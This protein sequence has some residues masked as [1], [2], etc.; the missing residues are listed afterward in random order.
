M[1]TV[2]DIIAGRLHDVGCRH[3]FGMPGGEVL[4]VMQALDEAGIR[5]VLTKHENSAGYMAEGSHHATG[6][7]GV[8]LTT[9]GPGLANA[10]NSIANAYQD[11]VPLIVLSGCIGRA[12]AEHFTHQVIDQAALLKPVSKAQFQVTQGSVCEVMEKALSIALAD[13]P[14]PVHIDV[15][16]HIAG[17]PA[18]DSGYRLV[19][20]EPAIWQTGQGFDTACEMINRSHKPIIIA[21]MGALHHNVAKA[22]TQVSE[23]HRVPVITTYKAKGILDENSTHCLGGHGLSPKSDAH[24]LR[25]LKEA[26]CIIGVGYDPIEM[27]SGW[28]EPWEREKFV[29]IIHADIGHGMHG[30]K[31][32]FV[33][34]VGLSLGHL[35]ENA[36]PD[37]APEW[38]ARVDQTRLELAQEFSVPKNWGPHQAFDIARKLL[39][40]DVVIT[41]DSGA[42]RILLSQMWK[43]AL[44][45]TFLQSSAFCT[46]GVSLP[47]A[48]GYQLANSHGASQ[49]GATKVV[50][51]VGDAG[52][53]M[54]IGELATLRDQELELVIVVMVDHSLALIE[55]KQSKS[56]L[57]NLGVNFP[58]TDFPKI[59]KAYGGNGF[60]VGS[61]E[62]MHSAMEVALGSSGFSLIACKIDKSYYRE[63]F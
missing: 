28:I 32:R 57:P 25:L 53:E 51:F 6:T 3:A 11:Q 30:C 38:H 17:L 56:Q 33:G 10:V 55:L 1:T 37:I 24:V 8:L 43:C 14:G 52:L 9:I 48:M 54:V 63:A 36:A 26:D 60:E 15:P 41:A 58:G 18:K 39:P 46:M 21:G 29:D 16:H 2:A 50:A 19:R 62:A 34:H 42:H 35:F 13:P 44:P 49:R 23:T 20:S 61:A 12:E 22:I 7:P 59:A 47:L 27:R 40:S 5:F 31:V 4:K 45:R